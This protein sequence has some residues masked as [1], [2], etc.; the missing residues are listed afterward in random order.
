MKKA[1]VIVAALL[2]SFAVIFGAT[3]T[4]PWVPIVKNGP[5]VNQ[6]VDLQGASSVAF[7][8]LRDRVKANT[9]PATV[10]LRPDYGVMGTLKELSTFPDDSTPI[11]VNDY[12]WQAQSPIY[13]NPHMD[14]YW[15]QT[16]IDYD[17]VGWCESLPTN[18]DVWQDSTLGWDKSR[19]SLDAWANKEV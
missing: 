1:I 9:D 8:Y 6:V 12:W 4:N 11:A 5:T 19:I 2:I 7:A 16:T 14:Y 3:A 18:G 13:W 10:E 17:G 15:G